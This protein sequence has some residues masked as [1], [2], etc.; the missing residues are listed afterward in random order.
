MRLVHRGSVLMEQQIR[1]KI[2]GVPMA[3][4]RDLV[5]QHMP[6]ERCKGMAPEGM[7]ES[8]YR[9][10]PKSLP[11]PASMLKKFLSHPS[12]DIHL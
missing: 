9:D 5:R 11:G 6:M 8:T 10:L 3:Q 4:P 12:R 1:V 7:Q 2:E